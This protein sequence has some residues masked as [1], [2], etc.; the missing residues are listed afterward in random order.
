MRVF[1]V[2]LTNAQMQLTPSRHNL[3]LST[4]SAVTPL[5]EPPIS[6]PQL[7]KLEK[8]VSLPSLGTEPQGRSDRVR[9]HFSQQKEVQKK[10]GFAAA[11][12]QEA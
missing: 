5:W 6:A 10:E 12:A 9:A 1:R 8:L 3:S 4:C 11:G 7:A 2:S